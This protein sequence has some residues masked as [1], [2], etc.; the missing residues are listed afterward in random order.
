M[1][2]DNARCR[3]A[4]ARLA[5]L[6]ML[7]AVALVPALGRADEA[8]IDPK[9]TEA[10]RR[11][12]TLLTEA[13]TLRF[14][15][16]SYYDLVDEAGIKIKR[17]VTQEVALRR[18]D[19]LY[20]KSVRDDGAVSEAWYDGAT[21]TI[22]PQGKAVYARIEAPDTIDGMLDFVQDNYQIT[23][24]IVDLLYSDLYARIEEHL[25]SGLHLGTR[26]QNGATV[27]HLSFESTGGDWQI[28][29]DVDGK[30]LPRMLVIDFV[31]IPGQPERLSI[32]HDWSLDAAVDET[33]FHFS[34]PEGWQRVE[35][36]R[37]LP[38][39]GD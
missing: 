6:V 20:F 2:F 18:P 33:M 35:L 21:L 19:R 26:H 7:L 1:M 37:I 8:V 5:S 28:W 15:A 11:M 38:P 30:P 10:L 13:K 39:R 23:V 32:L 14:R 22:A 16:D 12:S 9:S 29:I 24:P 17:F 34:P 27:D 3:R 36:A 25:L 4:L 31:P